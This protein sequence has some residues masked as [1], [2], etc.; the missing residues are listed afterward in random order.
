MKVLTAIDSFKGSFSSKDANCIISKSFYGWSKVDEVVEIAIADG[1]EGTIES[2]LENFDGEVIY[3]SSVDLAANDI[4]VRLGW[5][6]EQKIAIIE[7]AEIVGITFLKYTEATHPY[8]T[9]SYG[10]GL[11]ISKALDLGATQIVI[12]LGGTG[13]IDLGWGLAAALGIRFFDRENNLLDPIPNNFMKAYKMDDTGIDPRIERVKITLLNDVNNPLL[14]GKGAIQMFGKQKGLLENQFVEYERAATHF[15]D[16]I[17]ANGYGIPGDG[18]AGGIG[19]MLRNIST[20][21]Y[22]SGFAFISDVLRLSE[23]MKD[24]DLIITG[25]GKMDRQSLIGKVPTGISGLAKE[26]GIPCIAFTGKC[27][28]SPQE[29]QEAG[30]DE[31]FPIVNQVM[32]LEE[33]I[34]SGKENLARVSEALVHLMAISQGF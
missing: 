6:E 30:I 33:A 21:E 20:A 14:G 34:T 17:E 18:A 31:V 1:G 22:Q 23:T 19:F 4:Q 24:C 26:L 25:E 13:T 29:Y 2:L 15:A 11:L 27:E 28:L 12:G 3:V 5:I 10:V 7:V 16:I 9:N 32:T 8:F